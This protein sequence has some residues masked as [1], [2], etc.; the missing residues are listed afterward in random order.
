MADLMSVA[1][2]GASAVVVVSIRLDY[3]VHGTPRRVIWTDRAA[4]LGPGEDAARRVEK[5][6]REALE[7]EDGMLVME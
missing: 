2:K 3:G 5:S 1:R 7:G 6:I 4:P